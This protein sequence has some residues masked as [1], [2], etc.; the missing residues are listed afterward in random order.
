MEPAHEGLYVVGKGVGRE[1]DVEGRTLAAAENVAHNS[2]DQVQPKPRVTKGLGQWECL[3]QELA[4][5]ERLLRGL[6]H[7]PNITPGPASRQQS[8]GGP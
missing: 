5:I 7:A 3:S 2:T 4:K 6:L 1:I 8:R